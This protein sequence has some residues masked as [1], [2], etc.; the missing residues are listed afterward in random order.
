VLAAA[1][2]LSA[3]AGRAPAVHTAVAHDLVLPAATKVIEDRVPARATLVGLLRA[4]QVAGDLAVQV[5]ATART[6]F[7]PRALRAGQPYKLIVG[8]GGFFRAFEYAIDANRYLRVEADGQ[9]AAP[10]LTASVLRYPLDKTTATVAGRIDADHPSLVAAITAAGERVDLALRLAEIFGGQVDLN[11]DL[12]PGDRVEAVVE[13]D[14]HDGVLTGYGPVTAAILVNEGHRVEAFR[15]EAPDGRVGYYDDHGRSVRRAFLRSPLPFIPH[16]TSGFSRRRLHPV[17]GV[18]R[19]HLGVDYRAAIGT[20]VLAVAD[21]VVLS[22]GFSGASG[23]LIRLRHANGYETYY[24]HLSSIARNVRP[25]ARVAQGDVIGRV[26]ASGLVTGPHLDYRLRKHGVFVDPLIEQRR[27]PAGDPLSSTS[28]VAFDAARD[29]ALARLT[30]AD[31][32][33]VE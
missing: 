4:H 30:A 20:P 29:R 32:E 15:F 8:L 28:M 19:P 13:K 27:L 24:L 31:K 1:A 26:G 21:G 11:N 25:G 5:A 18:V 2:G 10:A 9:P 3:C 23:R 16:V 17:T 22:A 6:A 14:S 12:Q 7:N 33:P